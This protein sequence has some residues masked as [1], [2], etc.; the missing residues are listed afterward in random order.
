MILT[1]LISSRLLNILVM[2]GLS[3]A[4]EDFPVVLNEPIDGIASDG[5]PSTVFHIMN[6]RTQEDH[7]QYSSQH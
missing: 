7:C 1:L 3:C 6:T 2:I 5:R 4:T